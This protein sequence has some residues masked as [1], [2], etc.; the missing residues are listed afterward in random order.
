[1][2]DYLANRISRSSMR[3]EFKEFITRTSEKVTNI[4][5]YL[6]P[7]YFAIFVEKIYNS[8]MFS[9]SKDTSQFLRELH[10]ASYQFLANMPHSILM[11]A[12]LPHFTS[13]WARSWG[14]DT[15]ISFRGIYLEN[16]LFKEAREAI[17]T[18]GSCLRHGLIPNLLDGCRSPRYN[19]RDACWWYIKAIKDYIEATKSS[20]ILQ[21]KVKMVFLSDD[22]EKHE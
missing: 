21:E 6:I 14:R 16:H 7:R 10:L 19:C 9:V 3:Q 11:A 17:L 8:A 12:G 2:I 15:F 20:S 4:P 5:R 1:M 18:F 22:I 13:G